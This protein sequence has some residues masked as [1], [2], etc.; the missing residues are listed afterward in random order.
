[1]SWDPVF[2]NIDRCVGIEMR[3]QGLP[4]GLIPQLYEVARAGGDPLSLRAATVLNDG[5]VGRV[6]CITGIVGAPLVFG[7]IDGPLGA[8]VLAGALVGVGKSADVA[9]PAKLIPVAQA[10][11]RALGFEGGIIDEMQLR[12]DDYDAAVTIEKLGR[13]RKG[14]AHNI[15]GHPRSDQEPVADEFIEGMNAANK[16]T[17]GI[18][19]GGNEIGFGA[20]FDEARSI[21]PYGARCQCPCEDGMVTSTATKVLFPAAVSDFGAYAVTTALGVLNGRALLTASASKIGEAIEAALRY[22][23]LDGGTYQPG[24]LGDDGIPL[25]GVQ[26]IVNALRCVSYQH[27]AATPRHG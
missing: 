23:C 12:V 22:G 3:P 11:Q 7:E 24:K 10:M 8:C 1:M 6:A 16:P 26:A 9:V 19:D 4:I 20:I 13:N 25:W 15:F 27:F 17:V 2:D 21:V 18:G 5:S 14:V